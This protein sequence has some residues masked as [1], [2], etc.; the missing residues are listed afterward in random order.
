MSQPS[1]PMPPT[2]FQ[3][4]SKQ[5]LKPGSGPQVP[6]GVNVNVH[7]TGYLTNGQVFDSSIQRGQ[8]FSFLLGGGQVIK[9][10]DLG[11]A[12][13]NQGETCLLYIPSQLGYGAGG[14]GPIPPNSDLIFEIQCLG[15][16]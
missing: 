1:I 10:W 14:V 13:M 7:Y 11:V 9:G 15:W 2:P 3:Q 5:V 4:L 16:N 12:S 6:N 8:P